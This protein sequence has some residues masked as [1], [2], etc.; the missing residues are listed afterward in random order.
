M[1]IEIKPANTEDPFR[2]NLMSHM[3]VPKATCATHHADV[4]NPATLDSFQV[5]AV[6]KQMLKKTLKMNLLTLTLL[7]ILV[8]TQVTIIIYEDCDDVSGDCNL[9]FKMMMVTPIIQL[10]SAVFH[11]LA[12]LFLFQP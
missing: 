9:F 8:P 1:F 11:P 12:V 7:F 4:S 6:K 5:L 2:Q 10:F 3:K